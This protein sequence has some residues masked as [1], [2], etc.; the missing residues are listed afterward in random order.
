VK[1]VLTIAILVLLFFSLSTCAYANSD[2]K[3][4]KSG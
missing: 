4:W 1:K 3:V 2:S